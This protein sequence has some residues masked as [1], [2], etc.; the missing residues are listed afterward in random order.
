MK[1]TCVTGAALPSKNVER[2]PQVVVVPQHALVL[3]NQVLAQQGPGETLRKAFVVDSGGKAHKRIV[4]VGAR[5]G[6]LCQVL[7]GIS[8][9]ERIV[10]RGQHELK[11]GEQVEVVSGSK[12]K[13]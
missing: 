10:V 6:T 5:K 13:D 7:Q 4:K 11:D 9:G 8:T 3:D 1:S 2:R 12:Q